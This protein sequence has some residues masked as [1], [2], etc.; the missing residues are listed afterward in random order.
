[1]LGVQDG[2]GVS[3]KVGVHAHSRMRGEEMRANEII[4]FIIFWGEGAIMKNYA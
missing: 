1:M 4:L 3:D 2:D